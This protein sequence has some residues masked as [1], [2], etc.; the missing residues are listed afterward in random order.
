MEISCAYLYIISKYGYP[1]PVKDTVQHIAE[2]AKLGFTSVELEG[3]GAANIQYL[4]QHWEEVAEALEKQGCSVPVL[5]LVLPTLGADLTKE[6]ESEQLELF[7]M[8]CETARLFGAEGV[9]DNGPL[10][11]L[12]YPSEMQVMRHYSGKE[13]A[14][15][16]P[17]PFSRW[18]GYWEELTTRYQLACEIA[19]K[20]G[21][22]YHLHPCEGCLTASTDA[23]LLFAQAVGATNLLFNLDTSN[24]FLIKDN[25]PL[26]A[27]RLADRINYIHIS[28]N[29]GHKPEHLPPGEGAINWDVFFSTLKACDYKGRFAIDV[30]GAETGLANI[31]KAY[32][33][34]LHWM[35]EKISKYF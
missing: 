6:E 35:Q 32:T 4:Y 14:A 21:L 31:D 3:I 18:E 29:S 22:N 27:I 12:Q 25:L 17:L 2:M 11:P 26:S 15:L 7:E 5:C 9:L 13:I 34:S 19:A 16:H 28:D 33:E 10:Y 1:P 24:Q 23:F 30:G 8:G 20:Y